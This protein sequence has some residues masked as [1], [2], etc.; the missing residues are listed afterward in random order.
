[1]LI[2]H[3]FFFLLKPAV[4][5]E[6]RAGAVPSRAVPSLHCSFPEVS[7]SVNCKLV[8]PLC[9]CGLIPE[10]VFLNVL[11][12]EIMTVSCDC[13]QGL[14]VEFIPRGQQW[15]ATVLR[16]FPV[17]AAFCL[18]CLSTPIQALSSLRGG[19]IV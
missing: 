4:K 1:M 17:P 7:F 2:L 13:T 12:C 15:K 19:L 3:L 10:G 8:T 11:K 9:T 6:K 18:L 14:D 5:L 16:G